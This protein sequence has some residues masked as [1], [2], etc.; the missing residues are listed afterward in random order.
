MR[1]VIAAAMA[2]SKREIPHYYMGTRIDMNRAMS[3][4]QA[5]NLERPVSERILYL[6]LLLKAT[7]LAVRQIPKMNGFWADGAFKPSEPVHVGV[8]ISLRQGGPI[9]PAIHDVDKKTLPEIMVNLPDLVARVCAGTLRSS[10]IAD[11]TITVTSLGEEEVLLLDVRMRP[12]FGDTGPF[13]RLPGNGA[14]GR[15]Y[16]GGRRRKRPW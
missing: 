10:E 13:A 8:A 1:R 2:R 9:A 5:R 16:A 3:W 14:N 6:V 12:P 7:A 15:D 11:A 4:L